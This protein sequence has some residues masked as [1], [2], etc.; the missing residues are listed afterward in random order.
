MPG[1]QVNVLEVPIQLKP[2]SDASASSVG[3]AVFTMNPQD[4]YRTPK[5]STGRSAATITSPPSKVS[6]ASLSA[7][8]LKFARTRTEKSDEDFHLTK[9]RS[10]SS[11][12]LS[13]ESRMLAS[14]CTKRAIKSAEEGFDPR[15]SS[16]G[17][18]QQ[19]S[20]LVPQPQ[21]YPTK[22]D[23]ATCVKPDAHRNHMLKYA[24][25]GPDA[26]AHPSTRFYVS[27]NTPHAAGCKIKHTA[28]PAFH[29]NY[30]APRLAST[31]TCY[32]RHLDQKPSGLE[33][34][35]GAPAQDHYSAPSSSSLTNDMCSLSFG[36]STTRTGSLS[37][38]RLSHSESPVADHFDNSSSWFCHQ[39]SD[40][41]SPSMKPISEYVDIANDNLHPPLSKSSSPIAQDP[42]DV[43]RLKDS[44]LLGFQGYSLP[45]A[46]YASVLTLKPPPTLELP[47][48]RSP[49]DQHVGR[50]RVQ[51]WN[52][53]S[54]DH[55]SALS[56]LVND[57][58][59]LGGIIN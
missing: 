17:I 8:F 26:V 33:Y 55:M 50:S 46:E 49:F 14:S 45:E 32:E 43:D 5:P 9:R 58:G 3:S 10:K 22:P 34:T 44:L 48:F 52:D 41:L 24:E 2:G 25:V 15:R 38:R 18:L 56:Q 16:A 53:G 27:P 39:P 29:G 36:P 42:S 7:Y 21:D 13:R 47:D 40:S 37:P 1:Q 11:R 20:Y 19:P 31:V 12:S 57:H 4:K 28:L 35:P 54:E 30:N 6:L 51:T 23:T 59:Y